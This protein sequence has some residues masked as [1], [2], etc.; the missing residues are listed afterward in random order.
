M[1]NLIHIKTEW[2][3]DWVS[4]P[5]L[6]TTQPLK[7]VCIMAN[8]D[9]S[10]TKKICKIEDC[11]GK[12]CAKG[13]CEKHYRREARLGDAYKPTRSDKNK[14][15][16]DR[17]LCFIE[18]TD[19]HLNKVAETVIDSADYNKCKDYK[20]HYGQ[21]GY[22]RCSNPSLIYLH[23]IIMGCTPM[24]MIDH[25]D[26]NPLNNKKENLR[27]CTQ[28]QNLQNRPK[29]KSHVG[30]K[31]VVFTRNRYRVKITA[32]RKTKYIGTFADQ[33]SA[34]KAY[35]EAAL[36]Y[37]GEFARLNDFTEANNSGL[38]GN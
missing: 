36:K 9:V 24:E 5:F 22:V 21:H 27:I 29:N 33:L 25:K 28:F 30:Y 4:M 37:H 20:W 14:V 2:H 13:F 15:R 19:I 34:A 17:G 11:G 7:E 23:R 8:P 16:F 10:E 38:K 6:T 26:G 32:E 1:D 12:H 18:L 35:N 31:G 3:R